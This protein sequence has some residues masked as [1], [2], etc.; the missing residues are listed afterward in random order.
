LK[1]ALSPLMAIVDADVAARFGWTSTN[2]AAE[3][4][5]GGATLLQVRAKKASSGWLLDVAT[6]IVALAHRAN[7][8]VIVNDRADIARL[9][10]ADG[11]HVGQE[12]LA[13]ASIREIVDAGAGPDGGT[14]ASVDAGVRPRVEK[15]VGLSTHTEEQLEAAVRLPV[16]YIAVGPVFSTDTKITSYTSRGLEAV[17]RAAAR[18]GERGLPL[19][20]IGGVTLETAPEIIRA[21]ASTVAVISDLVAKGDPA[22][23]VRAYLARLTV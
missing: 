1:L 21:G 11:V 23:R 22:A 16:S 19:V 6:T 7:A 2:L 10:G 5:S 18:T 17:R 8:T 12:D 20:G 4:L 15:I 13:P 3:Y 9:S 14:D